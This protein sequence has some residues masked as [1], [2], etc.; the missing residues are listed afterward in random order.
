MSLAKCA[1][2]IWNAVELARFLKV[3]LKPV[4]ADIEATSDDCESLHCRYT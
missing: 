2:K 1:L 3:N 4:V